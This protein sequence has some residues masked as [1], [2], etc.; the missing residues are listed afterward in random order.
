M[1]KV[2]KL[3]PLTK[4]QLSEWH[5]GLSWEDLVYSLHQCKIQWLNI[6]R[7]CNTINQN[8]KGI[9]TSHKVCIAIIPLIWS[10]ETKEDFKEPGQKIFLLKYDVESIFIIHTCTCTCMCLDNFV[11]AYRWANNSGGTFIYG[12]ASDKNSEKENMTQGQSLIFVS[13]HTFC[14]SCKAWFKDVMVKD[15]KYTNL[16][17]LTAHTNSHTTSCINAGAK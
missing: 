17:I 11:R 5:I 14:A 3:S 2:D 15:V 4:N 12:I 6:E 9:S 16:R 8:F 10:N 1:W 7:K 13:A